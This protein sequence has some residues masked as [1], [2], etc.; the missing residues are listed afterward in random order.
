MKSN[1]ETKGGMID[2]LIN[3]ENNGGPLCGHAGDTF[4]NPREWGF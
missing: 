2:R 4:N 1:K 3:N